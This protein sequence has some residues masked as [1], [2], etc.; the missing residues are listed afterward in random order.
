MQS[1][2]RRLLFN[3]L[4]RPERA[5]CI[6]HALQAISELNPETTK[7]SVD[8]IGAFDLISRKAMLEGLLTVD[9]GSQVLPFVRIFCGA[10]SQYLWEDEEG[11]T[12][13]IEQGEGGEQGDP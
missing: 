10:H 2:Q 6:A 11:T 9:G 3:T 8:G 4:F 12:H 5:D 1:K 13:V 7:L